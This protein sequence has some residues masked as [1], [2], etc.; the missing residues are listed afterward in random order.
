MAPSSAAVAIRRIPSDAGINHEEHAGNRPRGFVGAYDLVH[1]VGRIQHDEIPLGAEQP[2]LR[3]RAVQEQRVAEPERHLRD[4]A[5]GGLA[6]PAQREYRQPELLAEVDVTQRLPD[7]VGI[8]GHDDLDDADVAV[9]PLH[10]LSG[11]RFVDHQPETFA[12]FMKLYVF[13]FNQQAVPGAQDLSGAWRQLEAPGPDDPDDVEMERLA[14]PARAQGRPVQR[15]TRQ[16]A[17]LENALGNMV[18]AGPGRPAAAAR[19]GP[20]PCTR[21]ARQTDRRPSVAMN[22]TPAAVRMLPIRK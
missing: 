5:G 14:E 20:G 19:S 4:V 11:S 21:L 17:R 2:C 22:A 10:R 3:P 12:R 15:R 7:N 18:D 8:G 16:N 13:P 1:V 9:D 6:F